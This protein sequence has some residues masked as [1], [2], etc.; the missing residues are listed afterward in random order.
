MA[1]AAVAGAERPGD[2]RVDARPNTALL[3]LQ[4]RSF[5]A[6]AVIL[7][8]LAGLALLAPWLPVPSPYAVNP[9]QSLQALGTHGH[10]FGTDEVGRDVLS[11]IIYGGR[12]TL[13]AGVVAAL[14]ST[15]AGLVLGVFAGYFASWPDMF[16]MRTLDVLLSFPFVL[17]AILIVAFFGPSTF[18]AL[19]AVAV[20]NLP[21]V[22]R[23]IR[24]ETLKVRELGFVLAGEALGGS[25]T[26][27][28][29]RHVLPNLTPIIVSTF[30]VNV[31]SLI[32]QTS[33]LSFLGLGT[34]PP[35]ADWGSML[36]AF[37]GYLGVQGGV[38]MMPGLA[39]LLSVVGFNLVGLGIQ[40]VYASRG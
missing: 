28:I 23:L 32:V 31:G 40:R 27:L 37:Q 39:L 3:L 4:N 8:V 18:H 35:T 5:V 34:Q 25:N 38:A 20:A 33:A 17:L 16:I 10:L 6:G 24:S 13:T 19:L 12:V 7:I 9:A 21:F 26:W 30:F 15:F 2:D 1:N 11:R 22:A 36:S 14:L 29:F